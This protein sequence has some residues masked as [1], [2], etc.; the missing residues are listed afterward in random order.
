[1][2]MDLGEKKYSLNWCSFVG[3]LGRNNMTKYM[4]GQTRLCLRESS[5]VRNGLYWRT[6]R[7]PRG[8]RCPI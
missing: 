2:F 3:I 1:M 8:Q 7:V 4:V 6:L 5:E